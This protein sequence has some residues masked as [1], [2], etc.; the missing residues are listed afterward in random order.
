MKRDFKL[1][2]EAMKQLEA[3][4]YSGS[5]RILLKQ[6]RSQPTIAVGDLIA[7]LGPTVGSQSKFAG[8]GDIDQ[9][10]SVQKKSQL[11]GLSPALDFVTTGTMKQAVERIEVINQWDPDPRIDRELLR[12][13]TELPYQ[14]GESRKFWSRVIKRLKSAIDPLVVYELPNVPSSYPKSVGPGMRRWLAERIDGLVPKLEGLRDGYELAK[15]EFELTEKIFELIPEKVLSS[16]EQLL[17]AVF[18]NPDEDS[19]KLVYADLLVEDGD[20]HGEFI[21][22]QFAKLKG[23]LSKTDAKREKEL[24][25]KHWRDFVGPL[26]KVLY[27]DGLEFEKGF[28]SKCYVHDVGRLKALLDCPYWLTAKK[29]LLYA[30][31]LRLF[32]SHSLLASRCRKIPCNWFCLLYTSPSPRD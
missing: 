19:Y 31:G 8:L 7:K 20:L 10:L 32:K 25:K 28:V 11:E 4:D 17:A 5:L 22:L 14:S 23:E 13:I 9:L 24:L 27:R 29:I 2:T 12:W 1:L 18:E 21:H 30:T 6:F 3:E 16:K 15:E 26:N